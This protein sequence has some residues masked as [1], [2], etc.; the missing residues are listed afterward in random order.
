MSDQHNHEL[1][2][3]RAVEHLQ[4]FEVEVDA[5]LKRRPYRLTYDFDLKTNEKLL[6][7]ELTQA[8]PPSFALTIGDFLHNL[9]SALDN[10]VYELAVAYLD[11][12]PLPEDRARRLEFPIFGDKVMTDYECRKK[13]GCIHPEAQAFIKELQP[14]QRGRGG[15]RNLLWTLHE[16]SAKDKHRFPHLGVVSAEAVTLA[17]SV[18]P[19]R[20]RGIP[21]IPSAV[22]DM[23]GVASF[24]PFEDRAEILRWSVPPGIHAEVNMQKPPTFFVGFGKGA[25]DAIHGVKV[26][27]VLRRTL[28]YVT[29]DVITPLRP[30]LS[31]H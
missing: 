15:R 16:L 21:T 28:H 13:I 11:I 3:A 4:R 23:T 22:R 19:G 26:Q 5:W 18:R 31:D 29:K 9:R 17:V 6:I 20:S 8:V 12:G 30:F 7:A 25:P 1:K 2:L 14:Y 10:L 24:E 27:S